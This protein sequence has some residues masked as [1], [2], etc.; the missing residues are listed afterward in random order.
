MRISHQIGQKAKHNEGLSVPREKTGIC[1]DARQT[2]IFN[3]IYLNFFLN[4]VLAI[5][6]C[7]IPYIVFSYLLATHIIKKQQNFD[8]SSMLYLKRKFLNC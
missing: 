3:D 2:P 6:H 8:S 5:I 7:C 1:L 4:G